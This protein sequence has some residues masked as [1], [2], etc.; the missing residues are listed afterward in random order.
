MV[1]PHVAP[2]EDG[3]AVTVGYSPPP[4]VLWGGPHHS[5]P[6]LLAIVYVQTM[7]DNVG[8][9]LDGD[10]WPTSNVH[11]GSSTVDGLE[12]VHDQ[13][14]LQL[15]CHVTLEDDPQWLVLNNGMS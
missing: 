9:K 13:L 2:T 1:H 15:D 11:A 8:H 4:V 6:S 10:A 14:F 7:N 12:R 3:H 5:I